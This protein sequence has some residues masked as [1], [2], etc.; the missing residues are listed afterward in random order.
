[1][2]SS[3]LESD[4]RRTD[5]IAFTEVPIAEHL[6]AIRP[7]HRFKG[8]AR[9][10]KAWDLSHLEPFAFRVD[11]GL[12]FEV[13]VV[14]L[15]SCH[16][17][18]RSLARDGRSRR[19]IPAG[20]LFNDGRE[21][22]VLCDLRYELSRRH[23]PVL[24]RELRRRTIQFAR[25]NPQNFVTMQPITG[26]SETIH[27]YVVF[28]DIARDPKRKGRLLLQV[29]SAYAVEAT[30]REHFRLRRRITLV[31]LLKATTLRRKVTG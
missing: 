5:S 4:A 20:E 11:P 18:T 8:V 14:V 2:S 12:G 1:M 3:E 28:F 10:G 23:L 31:N 19:E 29:Q 13:T 7:H 15:I 16:C 9:C 24:M 27:Q 17:F 26:V 6:E 22:R 21:V 25:D 30:F